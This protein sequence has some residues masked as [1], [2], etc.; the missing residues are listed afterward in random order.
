LAR[1]P[2]ILPG[3]ELVMYTASTG[4]GADRAT[5]EVQSIR[6]GSRKVLVR[7]GT[8]GRYLT[9]GHIAY[10]NQGTLYVVPFD[11]A[12][13]AVH[14][15]PVPVLD[16]VSYSPL[17]GYAQVDVSQTGTLLFRKG[18]ESEL[19]VVEWIDRS[20]KRMPLLS[21]PGRYGWLRLSPDGRRLALTAAESG[22]SSILVYDAQ[23]DETTRVTTQPGDYSGLT[24]LPNGDALVFGGAAGLGWVHSDRPGAAT[25]L[26]NARTAQT[27]W[28]VAPGGG[29]LAYYE[30]NLDTGFDLWTAAIVASD[31]GLK[32]GTPDPYL[33]TPAFEVYPSFSPDG[34]WITYASNESGAWEI[35]VRRFPDNGT[36]M[37]ISSSGG[38]VPR[39]SPNG[40]ELLYRTDA[41]RLMVAHYK[42][43]G[44]SFVADTPRSWSPHS[45]ADTG[46]LPNFDVGPDGERILALMPAARPEE[47]Q[48]ANHVTFML[49]FSDEVHRRTTSR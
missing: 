37:R 15:A 10:V 33:R 22:V 18:A 25:P 26:A 47:Q 3:G 12:T 39:W 34:R 1:W 21:K 6:G 36:K 29:R 23:K 28:S 5:I 45:L 30:R 42:A 8:F 40:R 48:S 32:L 46:V 14:G 16:D 43:A 27:P 4:A 20:G 24:W 49:N 38:V 44:D 9:S 2:Q 17:F 41:Q 13:L 35:Y 7:G 11:L 31:D 19:S